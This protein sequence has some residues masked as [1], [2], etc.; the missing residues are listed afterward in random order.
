[1]SQGK[2]PIGNRAQVQRWK[3][4]R[5]SQAAN[6]VRRHNRNGTTRQ[7]NSAPATA[8]AWGTASMPTSRPSTGTSARAGSHSSSGNARR[9]Q[10][11]WSLARPAKT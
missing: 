4:T 3:T 9:S 1:M 7:S 5:V 10:S 2:T 6:R 8:K 11:P